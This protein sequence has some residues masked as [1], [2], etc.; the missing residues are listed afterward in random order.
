MIATV[1]MNP[2]VDYTALISKPLEKGMV[3]RTAS[4]HITAGGKGINVSYI[5]HELGAET[6][7]YGYTAGAVGA[8]LR[9]QIL[10]W[11]IRGEWLELDGQNNRINLK[12]EEDG[13]VTELNG[14]GVFVPTQQMEKLM[15]K[16][17]VYGESD[18]IV[19]AGSIP[20]GA[21]PT[22]Y[23]DIME[24]LGGCGVRFAVDA[25]GEPL[26]AVLPHHP[27]VVK[28]NLPELCGL[29]GA[30]I[31]NRQEAIPY[32]RK[33]QEMGAENVLLSLGGEGALLFTAEG[34]VLRLDAPHSDAVNTVGAGD[35]MLAGFLA[36]AAK[37]MAMADCLRLGVAAGSATAFSPWL[38]NAEQIE[39]L[40]KKLPYPQSVEGDFA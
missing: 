22:L 37:G 34:K 27:F 28:P 20:R 13:V 38:A 8:M 31:T 2:A 15:E 14:T 32:G 5:L 26:R 35:S 24:E 10:S 11:G 16:L 29:F 21:S 17:R 4:E 1:T 25:E 19:L 40:L 18:I 6:C 33:M 9:A 30:E 12:I 3:N 7:I 36:G 23:A 39:N